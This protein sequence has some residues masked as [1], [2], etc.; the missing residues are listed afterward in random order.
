MYEEL[1]FD[2]I[3]SSDR[4]SPPMTTLFINNT[5]QSI[6]MYH[7]SL[8][9]PFNFPDYIPIKPL[10]APTAPNNFLSAFDGLDARGTIWRN[11]EEWGLFLL[12]GRSTKV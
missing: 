2:L 3:T 4:H 1:V 12:Q 5:I 8:K 7:S 9:V 11:A 10:S 6:Q